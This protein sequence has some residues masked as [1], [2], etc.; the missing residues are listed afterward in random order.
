[1]AV[2]PAQELLLSEELSS[3][4]WA[5]HSTFRDPKLSLG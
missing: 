1:M 2:R 3:D 4:S 5:S